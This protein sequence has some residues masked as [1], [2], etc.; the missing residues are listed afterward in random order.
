[1]KKVGFHTLGCKVNQYETQSMVQLF[2]DAGYEVVDFGQYADVYVINTC[3]VTRFGDKKSRQIVRR[4]RRN[5]PK[6]II[7]VVG[8]YSQ[9]SPE[10]IERLEV[11]DVIAGTAERARIVELVESF[12]QG[13]MV[14]SVSDIMKKRNYDETGLVSFSEKTRAFIKIQEGCDSFCSYCIIPY[15]RGPVRSRS[16]DNIIQEVT[17]LAGNGFKE[18]VLTGIHLTSYGKDLNNVTLMDIVEDIS[19][20][21]Q[22]ERIR[23]G[24]LEPGFIDMG[25]VT[26]MRNIEKLCPHFHISL[27]S[28][29]DSVLK[30]MNRKYTS[31]DY[32]NRVKILRQNLTDVSVTTDVMVGFPGETDNEFVETYNFIDRLGLT[33][34]HIFKYSPRKGTPAA[35]FAG[36]VDSRTKEERSNKLIK[37]SESKEAEFYSKFIGRTMAVLFEQEAENQDGY[38]QGHTKNFIPVTAQADKTITG[39]ICDVKLEEVKGGIVFGKIL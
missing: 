22:I 6:A 15:A 10:E 37:L 34:A 17:R 28:G 30:R 4:A 7:A 3:T 13:G 12:C 8:C 20:I 38:M 5:N 18:V 21:N 19:G 16:R 29:S 25:T 11:V 39:K 24:S 23:L 9:V 35:L 31:G 36:Q 2:K 1:M 32:E 14:K 33:R 27:Q 26:R